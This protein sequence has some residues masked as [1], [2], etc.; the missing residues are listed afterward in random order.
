MAHVLIKR[1]GQFVKASF[2]SGACVLRKKNRLRWEQQ[3]AAICGGCDLLKASRACVA[4]SGILS[5]PGKFP[6]LDVN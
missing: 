1:N 6:I 4:N 3:F 2:F 5:T